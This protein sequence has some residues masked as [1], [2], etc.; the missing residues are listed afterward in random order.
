VSTEP[1]TSERTARAAW[2]MVALSIDTLVAVVSA[3][4]PYHT[5]EP[6]PAW[7]AK[8]TG[9]AWVPVT[10]SVPFTTSSMREASRPA[11]WPSLLANCTIVPA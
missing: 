10:L 11:A 5:L 8:V 1:A 2:A 9:L 6:L 3:T 7:A 4:M